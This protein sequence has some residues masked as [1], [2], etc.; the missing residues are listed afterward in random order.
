MSATTHAVSRKA[1]S[2]PSF[3]R[4][5]ANVAPGLVAIAVTGSL[6]IGWLESDE[7]YLTPESGIGYWLGIYGSTAMLLLLIYSLRKRS[8]ATRSIGSIPLWFRLHMLL[9]VAGPVLILFHANFK[10]GALNSNVALF[11]M[12]IV[13]ASGVVGRYLYAKVH[14]GLYGRKAEVKEI[15]ADAESLREF[16]GHE[17]RAADYIVEELNSF[18]QRVIAKPPKG[19]FSSLWLGAVLAAQSRVLRRHIL[20]ET[21]RLIRLHGKTRGWSWWE[22]RKRL[23]RIR[24]V[25]RLYFSAVLKA[26]KFAFF[27]RLFALWHVLHLPLFFFMLLTGIVHVWAVHHF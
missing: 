25:V 20:N 8:K 3:T 4:S 10:L 22:R 12:L 21:R 13:A 14:M 19:L 17:L 7:E 11:S 16:L 9:G 2:R 23:A 26:A 27:E 18:S 5:I 15:L 1:G 24:E 6:L